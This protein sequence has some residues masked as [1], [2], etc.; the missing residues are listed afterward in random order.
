MKIIIVGDGQTGFYLSE[1]LS[2]D[3]HD[4]A[5]I[6][7]SPAALRLSENTQDVLTYTGDALDLALLKEAG[8]PSA[9][10]LIAVTTSDEINVLCCMLAGDLGTPHTIARVRSPHMAGA[11]SVIWKKV[12]L[13][14][15][16]NPEMDAATEISR[17]LVVPP[18]VKVDFFAK[19]KVEMAEYT[20]SS[21]SPLCGLR[22]ADL[23]SKLKLQILV[24]AAVRGEEICIPNGAYTIEAGD[25]IGI[26]AKPSQMAA[27]FALIDPTRNR[28]PKTVTIVGGGTVSYYL[29]R[30][31]AEN[32]MKVRI[33]EKD[34]KRCTYLSEALPKAMIVHGDGSDQQLLS[35]EGLL[36]GCDALVA[37]TD[38]DEEN[39]VISMNA[40]MQGIGKVIA[41]INHTQ[42][43]AI[44]SKV[45][46]K[47]VITPH[48]IAATH[49]LRYVRALQ[50][51]Q[52]SNVEALSK[53]M[54][55]RAEALE[56]LVSESFAG[57]GI[58]LKNLKIKQGY[59]IAC[60][61]RGRQPIFPK[62]DD[63]IHPGDSVI[64][65]TTKVG[66]NNLSDIMG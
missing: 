61:L 11:L 22:L 1:L 57:A 8:V 25:R 20:V 64:V 16:V 46:I 41:R 28:K 58:P 55:G 5:V 54:D 19:G 17:R 3:K 15:S 33:I 59:L 65:V 7:S 23:P 14:L 10:L 44:I 62:G 29:S 6:D 60:I 31:L 4:V 32:G 21:D 63:A 49:V 66:L 51:S 26:A 47:D 50:S 9:D 37:L 36:D 43:S 45:E 52:D 40:Q 39:I 18:S 30:L 34:E 53:I 48:I 38:M 42:L 35:E 27:L 2:A 13:S 24:C 12:G 56:F